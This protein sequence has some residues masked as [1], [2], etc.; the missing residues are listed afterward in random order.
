M[1]FTDK[2]IIGLK[3]KANKYYVTDNQQERGNGALWLL[4]R[5]TG[6]KVFYFA[7]KLSNKRV[8]MALGPYS[9]QNTGKGITLQ[10]ARVKKD[11]LASFLIQGL[12]PKTELARLEF[13]AEQEKRKQN[14]LG[15]VKQ[16]FEGYTANM[17][18]NGKKSYAEVA[19]A[20]TNDALTLLGKDTPA[21]QITSHDIKLVL[22]NM[23]KRGALVGSNRIR[24]YLSAAFTY[25]LEHDNDP[26]TMDALVT[27]QLDRNPVRD[28]PKAVK[29]EKPCD[30][31][32][33]QDEIHQLWHTFNTKGLYSQIEQV[34]RLILATGGQ[35][36]S[37]VSEAKWSEFNLSQRLWEIPASR[38][39]NGKAHL[40]PLN[41][42]AMKLLV[43]VQAH[44]DSSPYLFPH[45]LDE[46]KPIVLASM[47]KASNR[48]T[49]NKANNFDPFTPRD[50][51]RTCKTRMG[52]LGL[53]KE[54]RDR[55]NNHA[56]SDVSSKHYDRY[57]YLK[58]KQN[59]LNAWGQRLEQIIS[60]SDLSN[61]ITINS[62]KGI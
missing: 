48:F 41:D 1:A 35:R 60:A 52:E 32:L 49:S 24:S 4:I 39:K 16:L 18:A 3:S 40:I 26:S 31:E 29:N 11:E 44:R 17:K 51:R 56:N 2:E 12:N 55:I 5:P 33:S 45:R 57:D 7:Y 46:N 10:Q 21:N 27:Y 23:I 47:S 25:G 36:V 19:R 6:K 58:E 9:K 53:S 30:R 54:I 61:V 8:M 20:L 34:F 22:H 50:L 13:E 28:V 15:T 59:A 37:E 14:Q 43:D 42:I 38:T 62:S